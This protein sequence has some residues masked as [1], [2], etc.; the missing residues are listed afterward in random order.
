MTSSSTIPDNTIAYAADVL[1]Q[2][3]K[4]VISWA[5]KTKLDH[6]LHKVIVSF[7]SFL[8]L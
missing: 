8:A 4:E 3:L 1:M 6:G 2:T 7:K 5:D